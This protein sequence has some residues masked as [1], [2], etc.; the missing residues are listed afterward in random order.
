M[1]NDFADK[2]GYY[3]RSLPSLISKYRYPIGAIITLLFFGITIYRIDTLSS[4]P[5]D[6]NTYNAGV[7]EQERVVF[8]ED[9]IERINN[10]NEREVNPTGNIDTGR[11][12]PF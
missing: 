3:L 5:M 2:V 7:L 10:L 4:P 12:N 8:D 11:N 1:L 9:A 6:Q